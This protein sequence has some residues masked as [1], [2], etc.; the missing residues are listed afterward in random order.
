M[1]GITP[2]KLM[3]VE[4]THE[5]EEVKSKDKSDHEIHAGTSTELFARPIHIDMS[6]CE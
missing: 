1:G 6:A 5:E 2:S 4:N 3:E